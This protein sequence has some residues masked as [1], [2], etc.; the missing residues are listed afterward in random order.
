MNNLEDSKEFLGLNVQQAVK[1]ISFFDNYARSTTNA[2][3]GCFATLYEVLNSSWSSP[4]AVDFTSVNISDI[5]D[6]AHKIMLEIDNVY[7][8]AV[9]AAKSLA[10]ANGSSFPLS[11]SSHG[12]DKINYELRPCKDSLNGVVGMKTE[13]VKEAL[14]EFSKNISNA[15]DQLASV[16]DGIAFYDPEGSVIGGYHKSIVKFK[17]ICEELATFT[18]AKIREFVEQEQSK[19]EQA[20]AAAT[21]ALNS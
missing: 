19:I 5:N 10:A 18:S 9:D 15:L 13:L 12:S 4:I 17:S 20:K 7:M 11:P 6:M 21:D 14:D 8:G 1:D 16:P 2:L 3:V